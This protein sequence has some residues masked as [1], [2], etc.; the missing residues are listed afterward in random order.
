MAAPNSLTTF[1][2]RCSS[3]H[4]I[5]G[6]FG[7]SITIDSNIC[8]E[9]KRHVL[10]ASKSTNCSNPSPVIISFYTDPIY[11]ICS[12]REENSILQMY[13]HNLCEIFSWILWYGVHGMS[14]KRKENVLGKKYSGTSSKILHTSVYH[15]NFQI[16]QQNKIRKEKQ[17]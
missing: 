13:D 2:R 10:A 12:L 5:F 4:K 17:K 15:L 8:C 1:S 3:Y 11:L 16:G 14:I 7:I 6:K 9:W